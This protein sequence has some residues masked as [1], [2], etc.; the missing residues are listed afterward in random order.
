MVEE[1]GHQLL[2][3]DAAGATAAEEYTL[4]SQLSRF[5]LMRKSFC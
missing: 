5:A 4:I 3:G 1:I 2:V